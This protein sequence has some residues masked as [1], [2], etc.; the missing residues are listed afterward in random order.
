ME[1][2]QLTRE[3]LSKD[4]FDDVVFMLYA[5]G[6]AMAEGGAVRFVT[7]AGRT[8]YFN[9]LRDE[10][11]IDDIIPCFP[12][13][14]QCHFTVFGKGSIVPEGWHYM[15]LGTG[16]HLILAESVRERFQELIK[17]YTYVNEVYRD[18]FTLTYRAATGE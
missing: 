9:Y 5:S 6:G 3:L 8:Y 18:F 10:L 17:D 11:Q 4:L 2:I 14:T 13:L 16:N 15:Y 12:V 1:R 7:R